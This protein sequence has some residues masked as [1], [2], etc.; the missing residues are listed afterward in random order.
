M[1]GRVSKQYNKRKMLGY[2]KNVLVPVVCYSMTCGIILGII[3]GLYTKLASI[4]NHYSYEI[5][6]FMRLN[7][8]YIPL[9]YLGII[10]ISLI[11]ALL[12]KYTPECKGSGVP[13]T[14]G[15]LRGILTFR[16]LR[17]FLTTI[18]SSLLSYTAG[19]SLGSEGPS[20][21]IGAT[22]AEGYTRLLRCRLAWSKYIMSAG[23][24]TGLAIA[25]NAPLTGIVF[26][27][28]E[29]HKKVT[30][31]LILTASFSVLSGTLT[32]NA[33][34]LLW[35]GT[36]YLF[37]FGS[38][39]D[40]FSIKYIWMLLILGLVIGIFSL[41]FN[42]LIFASQKL[43]KKYI[44]IPNTLKLVI[45]FVICASVGLAFTDTIGGGHDLILK[46]AENSYIWWILLILLFTKLFL[47]LLSFNSGATGGL[48]IP[49]LSIGAIIGGLLG[50]AFIQIG[51][52]S[53]YYKLIIAISMSAFFGACVRTPLTAT[54]LVM[55]VTGHFHS[56][57][58]T[59][60]TI[61]VA[62][63]IAE[64]F[65]VAPLYD[66]LLEG[67]IEEEY[68]GLTL[69]KTTFSLSI[70]KDSFIDQKPIRDII[71]PPLSMISKVM[72]ENEEI[73][74][75]PSTILKANDIITVE[76]ESYDIDSS[77]EYIEKL[78]NE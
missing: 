25:F 64:L 30:P 12:L 50:N 76:L 36:G 61:F 16:W 27:L 34:S 68:K 49:M 55:E 45:A 9:L 67:N 40:T 48:F 43:T 1:S 15:V 70:K 21:Q 37:Y 41:A 28:E 69:E 26:V 56:F 38:F 18:I 8:M 65:R 46:I 19:L 24:G 53:E 47:I 72:R 52:P 5:Y 62:Y 20:I 4:L 54:I 66:K 71:M 11:V 23:A 32:A 58:Y 60:I 17:V 29:V 3:V 22:G 59:A 14:E 7:P 2:L 75:S 44:K 42:S 78:V 13:R 51:L 35:G 6:N 39:P 73:L 31:L 74:P 57:L 63:F 33:I 10:A 77:I